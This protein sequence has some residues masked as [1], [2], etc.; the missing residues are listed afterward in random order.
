[1]TKD[2]ATEWWGRMTPDQQVEILREHYRL[3]QELCANILLVATGADD[4]VDR[5]IKAGA[6]LREHKV[7]L[8][9]IIHEGT[10]LLED[11]AHRVALAER[12]C[13]NCQGT[14]IVSGRSC[15]CCGGTGTRRFG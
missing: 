14:G 3:R 10:S 7:Q 2:E 1:M 4:W 13:N 15:V 9:K 12:E 6:R 5:A 11:A 8:R